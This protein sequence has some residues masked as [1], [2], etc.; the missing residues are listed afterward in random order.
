MG[1]INNLWKRTKKIQ[2]Y[3]EFMIIAIGFL[4][5][6]VVQWKFSSLVKI[7]KNGYEATIIR[8]LFCDMDRFAHGGIV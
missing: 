3:N 2:G 4:E 7:S 8:Y 5:C 1:W 6:S